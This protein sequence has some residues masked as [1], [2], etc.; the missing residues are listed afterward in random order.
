M[1]APS[2]RSAFSAVASAAS[3]DASATSKFRSEL[4]EKAKKRRLLLAQQ[5][6]FKI[7]EGQFRMQTSGA[8]MKRLTIVTESKFQNFGVDRSGDRRMW[9]GKTALLMVA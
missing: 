6:M 3:S 7:Q 1:A 9:G 5:V 4:R 8:I 2:D